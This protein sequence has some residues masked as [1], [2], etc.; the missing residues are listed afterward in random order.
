M[1]DEVRLDVGAGILEAVANARLRPEVD[2]AVELDAV[3]H[4]LERLRIGKIGPLEPKTVAE[5]FGESVEPS[6]LQPGVVIIVE[7][8]NPDDI[9][10]AALEQCPRRRR[11]D[12]TRSTRH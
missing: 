11:T 6:L 2:D 7:V 9:L 10:A 4:A 1:A 8:I 5:L 12:E 3:G